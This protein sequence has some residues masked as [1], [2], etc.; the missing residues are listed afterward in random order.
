MEKRLIG[1]DGYNRSH[2]VTNRVVWYRFFNSTNTCRAWFN[3]GVLVYRVIAML[4]SI[5]SDFI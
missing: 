3:G 1:V 2:G 5:R 4:M